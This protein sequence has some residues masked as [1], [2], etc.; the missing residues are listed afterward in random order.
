MS[1]SKKVRVRFNTTIAFQ[2]GSS[3]SNR[4]VVDLPLEDVRPY[5][6]SGEC[7]LA[8]PVDLESA[9]LAIME[10]GGRI[11]VPSGLDNLADAVTRATLALEAGV[12]TSLVVSGA[13]SPIQTTAELRKAIIAAA[14]A[15]RAESGIDNPEAEPET[16]E[17]EPGDSGVEGE[18]AEGGEQAAGDDGAGKDAEGSEAG[19]SGAETSDKKSKPA[20]GSTKKPPGGSGSKKSGS[21][22][23]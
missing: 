20:G 8:D 4:Q 13:D 16:P 3:Y 1:K 22:K 12:T 19:E 11:E 17:P 15:K 6:E 5:L 23:K 9:A 10:A 2:H 21:S 18:K 14:E 7:E